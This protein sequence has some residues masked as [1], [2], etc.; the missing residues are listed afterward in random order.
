MLRLITLLF[1]IA[2]ACTSDDTASPDK[3]DTP[4][5]K[6][7][8]AKRAWKDLEAQIEIGPR[9]AGSEG[10][11]Q[12]RAYLDRELR[13]AGM[14][15]VHE[16]FKEMTPVGTLEFTNVYADLVG[17]GGKDQAIFVLASH[18]DTKRLGPKFVGA[19]DAGSSTAALLEIARAVAAGPPRP[20][21]YRF[22]FLDGEEA[23][24]HDWK[25]PDNRYGSRHHVERIKKDGLNR[26]VKL[27]VLLDMVGDK[28]LKLTRDQYS[29]NDLIRIF[30][31]SAKQG[32]LTKHLWAR[33]Q[34][35]IDD[36][37]SFAEGLS[38]PVIDL[39]DFQYGPNNSYW[40]TDADTLDK[41]SKESLEV[42]GR[43]VLLSL[44]R[45]EER[46]GQ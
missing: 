32:K 12:T 28:Q 6:T 43:L 24:N 18:Y 11:K 3:D 21:T 38:I 10:A 16:S 31:K 25:D 19:N 15:P 30:E 27:C 17:T 40:H 26:R 39:I 23:V 29:D 7:F 4:L 20:V 34:P 37:I 44:P 45:L 36:H 42:I 5:D 35:I 9:F 33:K 2:A 1:C 46:Y 8:D 22:L 14:Q 41:C 13:A